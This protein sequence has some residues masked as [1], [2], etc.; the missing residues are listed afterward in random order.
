MHA[1]TS[2]WW[3]INFIFH[4]HYLTTL[5]IAGTDD[6]GINEYGALIE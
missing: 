3:P 4:M 5:P 1:F 6:R 2:Q